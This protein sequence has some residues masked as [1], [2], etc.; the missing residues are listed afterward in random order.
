MA[1]A[2]DAGGGVRQARG[3]V[4]FSVRRRLLAIGR[5]GGWSGLGVLGVAVAPRT[6]PLLLYPTPT[7]LPINPTI[8]KRPYPTNPHHHLLPP[9]PDH[10]SDRPLSD[11]ERDRWEDILRG[12]TSERGAVRGGMVFALDHAEAATEVVEVLQV[13]ALP[14]R[15]VL[16][17][18]TA[19]LKQHT[20]HPST[21]TIIKPDLV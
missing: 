8:T 20:K 1:A 15:H 5:L 17:N 9:P 16:I 7:P 3:R 13:G 6:P 11:L 10:H 14:L 2:G 21:H 19:T 12:L 18:C 4:R